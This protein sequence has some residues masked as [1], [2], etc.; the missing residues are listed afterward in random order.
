MARIIRCDQC[1]REGEPN[2]FGLAPAGWILITEQAL[3]FNKPIEVCSTTCGI[4][5]LQHKEAQAHAR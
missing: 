1:A 2:E 3:S 4:L 5:I